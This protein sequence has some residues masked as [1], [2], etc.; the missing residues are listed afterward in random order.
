MLVLKDPVLRIRDLELES[1]LYPRIQ[2]HRI[3]QRSWITLNNFLYSIFIKYFY[4]LKY[5]SILVSAIK[6]TNFLNRILLILQFKFSRLIVKY[7]LD[8]FG[9]LSNWV[10]SAYFWCL[11]FA[12]FEYLTNFYG[13]ISGHL[14]L[15]TILGKVASIRN[16]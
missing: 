3:A 9:C 1:Q 8:T 10:F 15:K 16:S 2:H 6:L 5:L 14:F 4:K 7:V 12:D 13:S 11:F